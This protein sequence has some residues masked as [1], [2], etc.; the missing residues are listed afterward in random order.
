MENE[1]IANYLAKYRVLNEARNSL[2]TMAKTIHQGAS[3][4]TE[5]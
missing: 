5:E 1:A 4:F 2:A 3:V